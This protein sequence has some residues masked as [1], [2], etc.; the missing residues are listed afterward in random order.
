MIKARFYVASLTKHA[1]G[2]TRPGYA[3]PAPVGEVILRPV[4]RQT[5]DNVD[6]ASSTPSGEFRMAI[7]G[8]AVPTFEGM[9]GRDVSITIA[10]IPPG[11]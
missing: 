4:T 11:E 1:T 6:W 5:D 8:E 9:I 2:N 7:R 10:V 3:D